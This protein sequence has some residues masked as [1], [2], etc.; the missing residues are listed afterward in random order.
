MRG[1]KL[2]KGRR[3]EGISAESASEESASFFALMEKGKL[4]LSGWEQS[5]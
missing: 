1:R 5:N 3:S 2:A 4:Y